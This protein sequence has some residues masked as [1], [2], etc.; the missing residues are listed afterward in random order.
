M[1]FTFR[2]ILPNESEITLRTY[3]R[4]RFAVLGIRV[5]TVSFT[6]KRFVCLL[7][8]YFYFRLSFRFIDLPRC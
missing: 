4:L 8:L 2:E 1:N 5:L 7:K 3:K 6:L